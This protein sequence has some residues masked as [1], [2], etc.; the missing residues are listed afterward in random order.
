MYMGDYIVIDHKI[1]PF[2][3]ACESVSTGTSFNVR[4]DD[5]KRE[6]FSDQTFPD[7]HPAACRFLRPNGN[8]I[9]CTIHR[10]SPSQCKF[11][12]C[13]VMRIFN[14]MGGVIGTVTGT[15]SLH[16]DDPGLRSVWE[17]AWQK[18]RESDPDSEAK[19]QVFLEDH[20]YR[21]V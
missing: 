9:Q 18:I 6:I 3:Y 20:G 15:L 19:I 10:D 16:S 4:V 5:D 7:Q 8:L 17:E 14:G 1:G 21:V 13:V 12:R 2:E 11:Y